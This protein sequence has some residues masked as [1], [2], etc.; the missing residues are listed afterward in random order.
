M[1]RYRKASLLQGGHSLARLVCF[2]FNIIFRPEYCFYYPEIVKVEITTACNMSC[3][4][5]GAAI[6]GKLAT[7]RPG[8]HMN[9][10]TLQV[11]LRN[12][13]MIRWID[14]Q[15]VGEPLV[16]PQFSDILKLLNIR[17]ISCQFTT[18]GTLLT[19]R[20]VNDIANGNVHT[21]TVSLSASS[22]EKYHELHG[23]P[24]Y[25]NVLENIRFLVEA[26]KNERPK[27]R[28][29][30]VAMS[31]NIEE[32]IGLV[33]VAK[34]LGVDSLVVSPYKKLTD[35]DPNDAGYDEL[36]K[37]IHALKARAR[38]I[39]MLLEMEVPIVD[40]PHHVNG[41]GVSSEKC[42]WPW[43]SLA[44]NVDGDVMPCCYSMGNKNFSLG[45]MANASIYEIFNSREYKN[46]R[47]ALNTGI[48]EGTLCHL[49]NDHVE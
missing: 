40:M 36:F 49:C 37:S 15:G 45:N 44:V 7:D 48:T 18:N 39:G 34:G 33:D 47:K 32:L 41:K 16:H 6:S 21:I 29:L 25:E 35:D 10:E 38:S 43:T 24:I 12:N 26:R 28:I 2:G 46:F 19:G 17:G 42:L 27:I 8:R 31:N 20:V 3:I 11:I 22:A 14:L 1:T 9:I 13:P 4:F 23:S 5:C 30:A